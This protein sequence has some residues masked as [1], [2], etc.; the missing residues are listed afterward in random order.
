MNMA[1][2]H[3]GGTRSKLRYGQ[4]GVA[5]PLVI[6]GLL[7]ML[8]VAGLAIDSSHA[9]ANKTRLQNSV[10]AAALAAAKVLSLPADT[11]QATAAAN[12]LLGQNADGAGNHEFDDA[13][14]AGEISVTIQYSETLN[15][16]TPGALNGPYVRVIAQNFNI[17]TTLSRVLGVDQIP[18]AASAVAGPS[19]TISNAC[20]IAPLVVCAND[21]SQPFFGFQENELRV[22]KPQPGEHDDVGPGNY[23]LLRLDCGAG[24][25]CVRENMAGSFEQCLA[26]DQAVETEPGVTAGPTSQ[27]FN[28]RFG[29]YAGGGMNPA[30]YPPD[31]VVTTPD[32]YLETDD[33]T[34]PRIFQGDTNNP[35]DEVQTGDDI[36]YQYSDYINDSQN[37]PHQ[38][39]PPAGAY[40]RR[41]M[42]MPVADCNGD[43]SGQSTLAVDGFACFFMLQPILGGPDKEI[44]GQFVTDCVAGGTPGP[45]P[46]SGPGPYVIQ[47]YKD[48]DSN[49]S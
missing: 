33:S 28:T 23:K 35:D 36:D 19:P 4:R 9:L 31:V 32:P 39:P 41:V 2:H 18:V 8:A 12:S 29:Q 44:F 5:L 47:L 48:P 14:D 13:Y 20:D 40:A 46:G 3:T 42:A 26:D 11:V 25:A 43:Q 21:V 1:T 30:D 17:Q 24:G 37:G 49:D 38:N 27:G 6:A 34:P 10:D 16:F 15:P 22:L 7:A 45:N